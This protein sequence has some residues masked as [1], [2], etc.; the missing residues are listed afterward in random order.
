[1]YVKKCLQRE[2]TAS[3]S[4]DAVEVKLGWR[5]AP[6]DQMVLEDRFDWFRQGLVSREG[7]VPV[8]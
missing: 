4:V 3:L 6:I 7:P 2:C 5:A 1:M 8:T